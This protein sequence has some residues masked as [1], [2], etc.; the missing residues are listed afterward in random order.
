[1][2]EAALA[3]QMERLDQPLEVLVRLDVAGVEHELVVQLIPLADADDVLLARLDAEPLVVGVVDD[4]D[5]ARAA[6]ST[7]R[8]MSR[9]ELSDTV[10]TRVA[11]RAASAIDVRA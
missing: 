3:H 1:M 11:R 7:N 5:L 2:I 6:M 4:V 8:R 9:F 10:S